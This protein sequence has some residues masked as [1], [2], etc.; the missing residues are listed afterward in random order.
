MGDVTHIPANE[1]ALYCF[2]LNKMF[3]YKKTLQGT[4]K[5]KCNVKSLNFL[6]QFSL[7]NAF[8]IVLLQSYFTILNQM[9]SR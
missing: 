2:I 6:S 4:F 7:C 5:K 3:N 9:T 8:I 1:I